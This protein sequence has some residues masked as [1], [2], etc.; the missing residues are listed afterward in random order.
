[1]LRDRL[2]SA[3]IPQAHLFRGHSFR[4]GGASWAFSCRIPEELIQ[5]FGDWQSDT[6]KCYLD[7]SLPLRLYVSQGMAFRLLT[8]KS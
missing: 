7:I 6:Y 1:M 2:Q 5:G 4:R 3:G 8:S